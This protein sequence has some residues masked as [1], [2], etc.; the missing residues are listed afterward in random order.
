MRVNYTTDAFRQWIAL[1]GLLSCFGAANAARAQAVDLLGLGINADFE[2][3]DLDHTTG[4]THAVLDIGSG[5][6]FHLLAGASNDFSVQ[7]P[8]DGYYGAHPLPAPFNGRQIGYF[9]LDP[10]S[11]G[12]IVSDPVG[13][14]MAAQNYT[15]DVAVGARNNA[16]WSDQRYLIG[17]RTV[18]GVDLGTFSTIDMDPGLSPTNISDLQYTLSSA[19]A[20]AHVGEEVSIVIRGINLGTGTDAP[21]FTQPNFDNVR[22]DGTL[23]SPNSPLITIDRGTGAITLSKTGTTNMAIAGYSLSSDAGSFDT[24]SWTS[25]AGH[26]DK[27]PGNGSVDSD[28]AWTI[29]GEGGA[30]SATGLSE[31]EANL[32]GP[33]NGGVLSNAS[34]I[35]LGTPWLQTPFEDVAAEVS[36]TDG[37]VVNAHVAYTGAAIPVGDLTGDGDIKV[38]DWTAFKNGQ[39][40]DFTDL[41]D[42]EGYLKGDLN[43]DGAHNLADFIVFRTQYETFN[44]GAGSF[45]AMLAGVPEPST[46]VMLTFGGLVSCLVL[47]RRSNRLPNV[48][49]TARRQPNVALA[50]VGVLGLLSW[51]AMS[52]PVLGQSTIA[53]WSFDSASLTLDAGNITDIAEETGNHNATVISV[54]PGIGGGDGMTNVSAPF[55][56]ATDSITGQFGE[57]LRFNGDNFLA[58]PNLTELMEAAGGP[59]FSVSMWV[60]WPG[61]ATAPGGAGPYATL[62]DW[63]NAASGTG[64]Q[65]ESSRY[66]YGFGP[67]GTGDVRGQIRRNDDDSGNGDDI[68]AHTAVVPGTV[69]DGSWHMLTWTA[70]TTTGILNTYFDGAFVDA[71]QSND[72]TFAMGNSTSSVG[73]IGLKG[74]SGT[75]QTADV[76]LDEVWVFNGVLDEEGLT[77]LYDCNDVSGSVCPVTTLRATVN[78]LNGEVVIDNPLAA[79]VTFNS[80]LLGSDDSSL[81]D[82]GWNPISGQTITGFP[83]GDGSGNGWESGGGPNP[84]QL[85]EYRL[86]GDSTLDPAATINLGNAYDES[87]DARDLVF[88]YTLDSGEI[89]KGRVAYLESAAVPGD[90]NGDGTVNAADYTVWRNHLGQTFQ[91]MNEDPSNMDGQVTSADYDFWKAHFGENGAGSGAA[92]GG[93]TAAVP[94]PSTSLL[95]LIAGGICLCGLSSRPMR[96]L[97]GWAAR[98]GFLAM[99]AVAMAWA[100]SGPAS[101]AYTLDREYHFGDDAFEHASANADVGCCSDF[102]QVTNDS[103]GPSGSYIDLASHFNADNGDTGLPTYIDVSMTGAN[104]AQVRPGAPSGNLGILFDGVGDYLSGRRFNYPSNAPGTKNFILDGNPVVGPNNYDGVIT[105]GFQL[106]VYPNSAGNGTSEHIVN[107]T[108]QHGVRINADGEWQL[109]YNNNTVDSN[110]AVNFDQWSHVM[111]AMPATLPNREVLYVDGVA[112]AAR[113]S[114]YT[115]SDAEN[116]YALV[117]GADT[118]NTDPTVG[119]SDWFNGVLDELDMFVWGSTYDLASNTFTDLGQFDYATDNEF[120]AG[121]LT[122][123]A[124]DVNQDNSLTQA[125][126]DDFVSGFSTENRVNGVLV[127]DL[128]TIRDGDL[129]FDGITDLLDLGLLR[130]AIS[131]SGS[132]S[133]LNLTALNGLGVPEPSALALTLLA[134]GLIGGVSR[135]RKSRASSSVGLAS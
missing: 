21:A 77:N 81:D 96:L 100:L 36:L 133:G 99:A 115:T 134:G 38:A 94:E 73:A 101:A 112:I 24:A 1:I 132:G 111:V 43:G 5:W 89:I 19:D 135:G 109:R 10:Y 26:Y 29:L 9:N 23:A 49:T 78:T 53:H 41:T 119:D 74:D 80:Y 25:I 20:A 108:R 52:G 128:N 91:L 121:V 76:R 56:A 98:R 46:L 18:D 15:L 61:T 17:L 7:D 16:G 63:G 11:V 64:V 62:G 51:A 90:Y 118:G 103:M 32:T 92:A 57:G 95:L 124:G 33:G 39:G 65:M 4:E 13:A 12:E 97:P 35:A 127:G 82:S 22:L 70:D 130:D 72:P 107:D 71:N 79:G 44:G 3:P 27:T 113:Q 88:Q 84:N 131:S 69:N 59:S 8:A 54:A 129:N 87:V 50:F 126:I 68:W 125:D 114:N 55:V 31:A 102:G 66:T 117:V 28:D 104:L 14:I 75:F 48:T 45:A 42:A 93:G 105:R 58:F 67:H 47:G 83:A 85:A 123:L 120:A 86:I 122:G 106:W 116:V 2:S 6:T 40:T 34:P 60:Q 37:S 110:V 30:G